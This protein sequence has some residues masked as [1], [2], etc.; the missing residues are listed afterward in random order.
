MRKRISLM[1]SLVLI[2]SSLF[3]G[4]VFA[5]PEEGLQFVLDGVTYLDNMNQL[6]VDGHYVNV[7]N[8]IVLD[9]TETYLEIYDGDKLLAM[10]AYP[11]TI[12]GNLSIAIGGAKKTQIIMTAPEKYLKLTDVKLVNPKITYNSDAAQTLPAGKK[13]YYN[14]SPVEFDVKPAIINGRLMVPARATFEKMGA[15]VQWNPDAQ[16]ITVTKGTDTVILFIGKDMM[17][18]TGKS[19]K[20]DAPAQILEGRTVVP[21]RAISSALGDKILYGTDNEMAVIYSAN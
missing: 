18:A 9:V 2:L 17:S 6:Q 20:L 1:L 11:K 13:V 10:G 12:V 7:G 8:K 15:Q 21:L 3:G 19:V 14:G 5:A 4:S 16:S